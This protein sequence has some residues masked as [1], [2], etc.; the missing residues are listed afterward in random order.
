MKSLTGKYSSARGWA[1]LLILFLGAG[2]FVAACGDEEVP[3]P[4]TPAP[5]PPAP[6]PTPPPP[7][8]PTP[9]PD[10][11]PP[12]TPVG[13]RISASGMDFIE[14]SWN[15]VEDVSGYDVQ[16][17]ANEAFTDEDEVIARTAEQISYRREDLG[18][19]T[20][21]Y[22]RVRS[23]AGTGE[24]RIASDWSTHVTG[25]T[26]AAPPVRPPAPTNL[27]V[28]DTGPN[29]IEWSWNAVA[30]AAG[31]QAQHS[32]SRAITD[33]DPGG[34]TTETSFR[35]RRLDPRTDRFMR[36]RAYFGTI[37][38]PVFGEWS[39]TD[40]GTSDNPPPVVTTALSAPT[41]LTTGS[42]T[43]TTITLNWTV[44]DDADTYEV[45]QRPDD[46]NWGS[47]TCGSG[48][49]ATV[50]NE[51]CVATELTRGTA[52]SFRVRAHPDPD[53]D[54][55]TQSGW[56]TASAR[57][58]GTPP[59]TPITGG[60]D[61]L[62]ITW[63]SDDTSITWFWDPPSDN[64]ISYLLA[65]LRGAEK[66]PSNRRPT[67]PAL[68]MA[69]TA[70]TFEDIADGTP[71]SG[72]YGGPTGFREF[73]RTLPDL[74][75]GDVRGL[76]VVRTWMDDQ[77]N[78]QYGPVSAM[79]ATTAPMAPLAAEETEEDGKTTV[80][81]WTV[82]MDEGFTYEVSTAKALYATSSNLGSC[83]D[84]PSKTTSFTTNRDGGT[85]TFEI[86][87]PDAFTQY[88]VCV[89]ASNK[90]PGESR[91]TDVA[92][93]FTTRPAAPPSLSGKVT[94]ASS[95]DGD[96]D[97]TVKI[98]WSFSVNDKTPEGAASYQVTLHTNGDSSLGDN[99]NF[100][101]LKGKETCSETGTTITLAVTDETS[102]G[103][104]FTPDDITFDRAS[105][106]STR[107]SRTG[108]VLVCVRASRSQSSATGS[109]HHGP[110]S[111]KEVTVSVPKQKAA[112]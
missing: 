109:T 78:R 111:S 86:K 24:D 102:S 41:G 101:A 61:D 106:A 25:M 80:L 110:W 100:A 93:Q 75:V 48:G 64:R 43:A 85:D 95:P 30:S 90:A 53:D 40:M 74:V 46:G 72:W 65:L 1:L 83:P 3:T 105:T 103:F 59:G 7:P 66:T 44:V 31:Y 58:S 69:A 12:A 26:A 49:D 89:R 29:Y 54:T 67:C 63:E 84:D 92:T 73:A 15:A 21:H 56:S 52:Y 28:T 71:S 4:T 8:A 77:D 50:T 18:A 6:T 23:A 108:R 104:K 97:T 68:T 79:W 94:E 55:L 10:P 34:F 39:A 96:P 42:E 35:V 2:L 107:S 22:L 98:E 38:E 13:L 5:P 37:S 20:S 87:N 88:N 36:V 62:N 81:E 33:S 9:E 91:W 76:C 99:D 16:Y 70:N 19:E 51:E 17:S 82:T 112:S 57:T 47:A 32:D 60:D 27:R 14:W 11:D 45:Q